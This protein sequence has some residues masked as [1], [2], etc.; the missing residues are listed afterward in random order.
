MAPG[1]TPRALVMR[2]HVA[3]IESLNAPQVRE[4]L[5]KTGA[6]PVGSS[7]EDVAKL[8]RDE[9]VKWGKVMKAAGEDKQ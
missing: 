3:S 1:G 2:I 7:P 5:A 8:L 6:E 4:V 9:M